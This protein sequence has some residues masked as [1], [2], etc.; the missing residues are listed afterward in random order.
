M[1][2]V[3]NY[4]VSMATLDQ[5]IALSQ[6]DRDD[7]LSASDTLDPD[8]P[9]LESSDI[10]DNDIPNLVDS[11]TGED[12]PNLIDDDDGKM[13]SQLVD[14]I[15]H[16]RTWKMDQWGRYSHEEDEQFQ[17]G[18]HNIRFS[19]IDND[20]VTLKLEG[21][22]KEDKDGLDHNFRHADEIEM[23][24]IPTIVPAKTVV[25]EDQNFRHPASISSTPL[26]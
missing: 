25:A 10:E 17:I 7:Q 9:R 23:D 3:T 12:M 8:M 16:W 22:V 18:D 20:T 2:P 6:E 4:A 19:T 13:K 21:E 24:T 1:V 11:E 15:R 5:R 26:N 14:T